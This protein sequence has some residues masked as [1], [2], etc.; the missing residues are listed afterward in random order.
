MSNR[1]DHDRSPIRRAAALSLLIFFL[2]A[3]L[4]L[5]ALAVDL[6]YV[7]FVR[8]QL[9]AAADTA[10][11]AAA[12]KVADG[13][14]PALAA[15]RQHAGYHRAGGRPVDLDPAEV[16]L[17]SWDDATRRFT[18]TTGAGNAVRVTA[19]ADTGADGEAASFVAR[20]FGASPFEAPV[21]AVAAV[22]PRDIAFVVDLSGAMNDETE[23]CRGAGAL[24]NA[25][26]ASGYPEI[27]DA[28]MQ[29]VF[30]DFGFGPYPGALEH[31]GRPWDVAPDENAYVELI[32]DGGPLARAD[33]S[34]AYRIRAGDDEA[35]RRRKAYK[36]IIDGQ[37]ARLMPRA[38]PSADR[39]AHHEYWAAYLDYLIDPGPIASQGLGRFRGQI[40]YMTY[41]QFM[42]DHGR[43]LK[44]D[45]RAYVP[46]SKHSPDCPWH[47]EETAGGTFAF[48]PRAQPMHAARRA[49]IAA[50]DVIK[51]RNAAAPGSA[52]RDRVAII[53]FDRLNDGGP[54]IEQP[55][56]HD[57]DSAMEVCAGLQAVGH[58]GASRATEAGLIAAREHLQPTAQGGR[59]RLTSAKVVVL[60]TAGAPDLYVSSPSEIAG[61][62]EDHPSGAF[63]RNGRYAPD[64]ALMQVDQMRSLR[65]SVLAVGVGAGADDDFVDRVA[66][67]GGTAGADGHAPRGGRG[68]DC[69]DRLRDL[70]EQIIT[71]PQVRLVK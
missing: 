29:Q 8:V 65:W 63:H 15:A 58:R 18:P 61:Y 35:T 34:E 28:P 47:R 11:L 1:T 24:D 50:L 3:A 20:L 57:Y 59:G 67:L 6:G 39:D 17:G 19:R 30:D 52:P 44:P 7:Y 51:R 53:A 21:Q 54:V 69:E 41:V 36:A 38:R 16:E 9:Q 26:G 60:L 2:A 31:V 62:A 42:M 66:R 45:G 55:L 37:I 14:A 10:A 33:V 23:P 64:A 56:T 12:E 48:P 32:R 13:R 27:A 71:H 43:D 40:G 5:V 22:D 68:A 4:G 46:L 49:L 25:F 70:V